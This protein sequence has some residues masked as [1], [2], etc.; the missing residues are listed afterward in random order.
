MLNLP[1]MRTPSKAMISVDEC[2]EGAIIAAQ[3]TAAER[4]E[5]VPQLIPV[6]ERL[7]NAYMAFHMSY[8][9]AFDSS[10]S[11]RLI[12]GSEGMARLWFESVREESITDLLE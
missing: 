3:R 7:T 6:I 8:G 10:L 1:F 9:Y 5:T 11:V 2:I 12:T 4:P